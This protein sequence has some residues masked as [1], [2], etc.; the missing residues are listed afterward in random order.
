MIG[1]KCSPHYL[2]FLDAIGL[3]PSAHHPS[4]IHCDDNDKIH[5]MA[6]D[7]VRVLDIAGKMADGATG[8][9]GPWYGKEYHLL[10]REFLTGIVPLRY[11]TR[12][13]L[14]FI[15]GIRNPS[16]KVIAQSAIQ[17]GQNDG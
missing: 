1:L 3:S 9:E 7:L 13:D 14:L 8:C 10:I 17:L 16:E 12:C 4:I 15:V 6:S 5:A 2:V 11:A